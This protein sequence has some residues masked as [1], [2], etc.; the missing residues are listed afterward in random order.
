M[1]PFGI[2]GSTCGD[3]AVLVSEKEVVLDQLEA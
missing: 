3:S 1:A 2:A